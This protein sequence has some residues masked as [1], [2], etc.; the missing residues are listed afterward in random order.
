VTN[1]SYETEQVM[2]LCNYYSILISKYIIVKEAVLSLTFTWY[3]NLTKIRSSVYTHIFC[4]LRDW[5]VTT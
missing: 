1:I 3:Q 4:T 2:V 5:N